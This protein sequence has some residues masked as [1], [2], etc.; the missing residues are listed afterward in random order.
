MIG[1]T[2]DGGAAAGLAV[3]FLLFHLIAV[4]GVAVAAFLI[5]TLVVIP[6]RRR[7]RQREGKEEEAASVRQRSDF[8]AVGAVAMAAFLLTILLHLEYLSRE[9]GRREAVQRTIDH[10]TQDVVV[11]VG[12][13]TLVLPQWALWRYQS[14]A[15]EDD[16]R[17][18]P[19]IRGQVT[20]KSIEVD[21][22]Q[23]G[24]VHA[25][26]T[27]SEMD[28]LCNGFSRDWARRSCHSSWP[29][30]L[31][32]EMIIT[33][34]D[35]L[36]QPERPRGV[37]VDDFKLVKGLDFSTGDFDTSCDREWQRCAAGLKASGGSIVLW[38]VWRVY[39]REKFMDFALAKAVLQARTIRAWLSYGVSMDPRPEL[40]E[41]ELR[42]VASELSELE[43][44]FERPEHQAQ[45]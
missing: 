13:L 21:L 41:E 19:P 33:N 45:P 8:L 17:L 6:R 36:K 40:W 23:D 25:E 28:R 10:E 32:T 4:V 20:A 11:R 34:I 38:S 27:E 15:T 3:L 14:A 7:A 2:R 26:L 24:S 16:N 44:T 12:D 37:N 29:D 35:V 30:L 42:I 18:Q 31:P 9:S 39:D 5:S 1:S 22:F 43:D